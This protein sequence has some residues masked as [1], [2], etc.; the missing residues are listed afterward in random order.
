MT[1]ET[2]IR[3]TQPQAKGCQELLAATKSQERHGTDYPS[4]PPE[5]AKPA[6]TLI[7]DFCLHNGRRITFCCFKSHGVVIC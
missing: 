2:G 1:V 6:N 5:E 3:V 4:E 7:S